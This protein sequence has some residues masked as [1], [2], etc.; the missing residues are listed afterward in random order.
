ML[1]NI[2][3]SYFSV[4]SQE[5]YLH[6]YLHDFWYYD[7]MDWLQKRFSKDRCINMCPLWIFHITSFLSWTVSW[8]SSVLEIF[9]LLCLFFFTVICV[10]LRRHILG[11]IFATENQQTNKT[12]SGFRSAVFPKYFLFLF[13]SWRTL[14]SWSRHGFRFTHHHWMFCFALS[15]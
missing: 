6:G 10:C 12:L 13:C 11:D 4:L 3:L 2:N 8:I 1:I 15:I 9:W 7:K 14:S 5:E